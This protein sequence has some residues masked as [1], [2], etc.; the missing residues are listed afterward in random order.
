M[1]NKLVE[2]PRAII[3]PGL[4]FYCFCCSS[5]N[6]P[7]Y[8]TNDLASTIS[9]FSVNGAIITFLSFTATFSPFLVTISFCFSLENLKNYYGISAVIFD[10][11]ES[12]L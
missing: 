5:T 10:G 1:K 8:A 6:L 4:I 3:F 12:G 9:V 2:F 11:L 7:V